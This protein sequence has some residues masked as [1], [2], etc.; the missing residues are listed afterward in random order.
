MSGF[1]GGYRGRTSSLPSHRSKTG[2]GRAVEPPSTLP[3]VE[4]LGPRVRGLGALHA[5]LNGRC[6]FGGVFICSH[7]HIVF[8]VVVYSKHFLVCRHRFLLFSCSYIIGSDFLSSSPS[9][10]SAFLF[11]PLGL[12]ACFPVLSLFA[13]LCTPRAG[14]LFRGEDLRRHD[15]AAGHARVRGA[16]CSLRGAAVSAVSVVVDG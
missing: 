4:G 14:G 15:A 6:S 12:S 1:F 11:P 8:L 3:R 7:H 13:R 2:W 9:F 16:E 5:A 10:L